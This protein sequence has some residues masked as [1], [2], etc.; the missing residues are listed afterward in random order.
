[1]L[2]SCRQPMT[3]VRIGAGA[4]YSGDRIQPALDLIERGRL[5][6]IVF[7]CLAERTIALAQQAK[8]K[9]PNAGYDPLLE[10]RMRTVLR[11]CQAN[12]TRLISNMGA[13][14]PTAAAAKTCAIAS[15]LGLRGMK[16][17]AIE[18]D[19]VLHLFQ[20]GEYTSAEL[21]ETGEAVSSIAGRLISAN[22]YLGAK[23]IVEC[24][25]E[26]ADVVLGGRVA[27]PALFLGPLAHEFGWNSDEW[28]R[29]GAGILVGHLLEC[30][31]Q[32]TGGY[33]ADPPFKLVPD[34]ANLGFP[35]ADV[36]PDGIA[37]FS[38]LQGTGG[39][40][41]LA[42]C[43]EQLLYEIHDPT[44]YLTPDVIADFSQ[45]QLEN[46]GPDRVRATGAT[47]VHRPD[48]LK[49]SLGYSDGF[50]GE[51]Q[52]TYVGSGAAKRGQLATEIVSAQIESCGCQI[53]ELRTEMIGLNSSGWTSKGNQEP[54]EVRVRIAARTETSEEA[55]MIGAIVEALYT[56]GPAAG[57][58]V[59]RFVRPVIAIA[60]TLIPR[61]T[62]R[63]EIEML[64]A[65]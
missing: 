59:F 33:F 32:L 61:D 30:A 1:M 42:T 24:L 29:L 39:L 62:V 4:G 15:S 54:A 26:G 22:A 35:F 31:G 58:G 8:S 36:Q 37:E 12:G 55:N 18:G 28:E 48:T 21:S 47:G 46:R 5:D 3:S 45:V 6:Y 57:G 17:A 19:D 10:P 7:E 40:V 23:P 51:G 52:I 16:V 13:A 43:K 2:D 41:S 34:L 64:V 14:N 53:R 20:A 50:I 60:S 44:R 38:K 9:D 27:D 65:Q 25:R 11:S 49:V 63:P 56:N